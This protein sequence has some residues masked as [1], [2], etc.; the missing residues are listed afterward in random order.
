MLFT[1]WKTG[2]ASLH[3]QIFTE[4]LY[5]PTQRDRNLRYSL[6]HSEDL[7]QNRERTKHH[8]CTIYVLKAAGT[9]EQS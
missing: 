3:L 5:P 4:S 1:V 7:S 6:G 9:C 8:T 2:F